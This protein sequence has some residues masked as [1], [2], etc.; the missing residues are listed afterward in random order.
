[1]TIAI[2]GAGMAG[3]AAA[4]RLHGLG[5]SVHV[6]DKGRGPGG[7]L[8]TR[9]IDEGAGMV[10][11]D[12]GAGFAKAR[13]PAFAA[14]LREAAEVGAAA[15]WV[16]A[17]GETVMAGVPGMNELARYG[18]GDV[19]V[20]FGTRVA[21]LEREGQGWQLHF[22]DDRAPFKATTVLITVPAPQAVP[23][24][25]SHR[26]DWAGEAA[27][28]SY[29]P[30]W[31]GLMTFPPG[32]QFPLPPGDALREAD[33]A[34]WS[35]EASKPGRDG[36][37]GLV[38]HATEGWSRAFLEEDADTIAAHFSGL[39]TQRFALPAPATVSAH[40]WRYAR[41]ENPREA[42]RA[43]PSL[44]LVLAGDWLADGTLEG[45]YESGLNAAEAIA[46]FPAG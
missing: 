2:I 8:A 38:M 1:M 36:L 43:D 23:L 31:A 22:E 44:G 4:R 30:V 7:R 32:T 15:P 40:R 16:T 45:A 12:H 18:L 11:L 29:A 13:R 46:T 41:V 37:A 25:A 10:R 21:V 28:V 33:L 39:V 42:G 6:F 34:W 26:P 24:L 35:A 5:H 19:P 17:Q 14:F 9:R 3:T 27:K 20:S